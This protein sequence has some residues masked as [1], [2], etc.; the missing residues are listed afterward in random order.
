M[1]KALK[2]LALKGWETKTFPKKLCTQ[3]VPEEGIKEAT[4]FFVCVVVDKRFE[5]RLQVRLL[6]PYTC[7]SEGETLFGWSDESGNFVDH[8][9][10]NIH[11]DPDTVV[12]WKPAR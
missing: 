3:Q 4:A 8:K 10:N 5:D 7:T 2:H 1:N 9:T 11:N 12:A 6:K